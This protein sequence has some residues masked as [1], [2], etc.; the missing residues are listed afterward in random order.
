MVFIKADILNAFINNSIVIGVFFDI[1]G[2]FNNVNHHVLASELKALDVPE[3]I[4]N[5]FII[6]NIIE[7]YL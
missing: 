2:A 1:V 6:L 4:I 5:G 7:K 3:M